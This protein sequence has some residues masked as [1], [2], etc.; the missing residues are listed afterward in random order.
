MARA[1]I[2][3]EVKLLSQLQWYF[4]RFL[5]KMVINYLALVSIEQTTAKGKTSPT[6]SWAKR[7]NWADESYDPQLLQ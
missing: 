3:Y 5:Y 1:N 7:K 6:N 2:L 4:S